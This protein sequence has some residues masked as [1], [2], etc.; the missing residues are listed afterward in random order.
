MEGACAVTAP[1]AGN[2]FR[3]NKSLVFFLHK[4]TATSILPLNKEASKPKLVVSLVSHLASG[5]PIVF[6]K[7]PACAELLLPVI[8]YEP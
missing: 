8:G 2:G 7:K 4:S 1:T 3:N 6:W 5:L